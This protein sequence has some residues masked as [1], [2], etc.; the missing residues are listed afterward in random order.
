VRILHGIDDESFDGGAPMPE[1]ATSRI[2][3]EQFIELTTAA[4]MRAIATQRFP[5][6]PILIGII[7]RPEDIGRVG[8]GGVQSIGGAGARAVRRRGRK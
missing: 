3:F 1:R 5:H 2:P 7:Y 6:G 8:G 4:L